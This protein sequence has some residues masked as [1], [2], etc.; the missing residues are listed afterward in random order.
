MTSNLV[1]LHSLNLLGFVGDQVEDF[2]S[3]L[4]VSECAAFLLQDVGSVGQSVS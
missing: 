1:V 3:E 2:K 4:E